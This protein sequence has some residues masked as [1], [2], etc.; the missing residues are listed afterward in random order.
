MVD[1]RTRRLLT[2]IRRYTR[3]AG[4]RSLEREISNARP[5]GGEGDPARRRRS[6]SIVD[7]RERWRTISACRSSATAR[8]RPRIRSAS[9][10]GLAWTEVGGELLT[11]EGV[12]MP[13]KGTM[14]VT[15][16]LR[17]V[18]KESI[19]AAT[20]YVALARRSSSAS[21]RRCSRR[22]DI[23]V[24]VPEGATPKDGPSAGVAMAT[25]IVSV[26]T[27]I[28]VRTDV[29]MT[30][31]ITL[32]GRVLPIGGLK[33]KLLA[34]L[35][36]GIK[37]VLIP[38]E[39]AKD[40]AELPRQREERAG[41][42]ARSRAW[43]RCWPSALTRKPEADRL[44]RG[45]ARQGK[46]PVLGEEEGPGMVAHRTRAAAGKTIRAARATRR[47]F[48][49]A[50]ADVGGCGLAIRAAAPYWK[51]PGRLAQ[52]VEHLVYTERVG[53]SSPSPPTIWFHTDVEEPAAVA[54]ARKDRRAEASALSSQAA[55]GCRRR[56]ARNL[57]HPGVAFARDGDASFGAVL[58]GRQR[59]LPP[60][61]F[62][63]RRGGRYARRDPRSEGGCAHLLAILACSSGRP[64]LPRSRGRLFEG[65]DRDPGSPTP[66]SCRRKLLVFR[67]PR[68]G[69]ASS[70]MIFRRTSWPVS[71]VRPWRA[72]SRRC[73]ELVRR[74]PR[75]LAALIRHLRD[76]RPTK[77]AVG[78]D[79]QGW[80]GCPTVGTRSSARSTIQEHQ[81]PV[82][83]PVTS[84]P[85]RKRAFRRVRCAGRR[86]RIRSDRA[87]REPGAHACS[88]SADGDT[89]RELAGRN[90][91]DRI[92]CPARLSGVDAD[93]LRV[94]LFADLRGEFEDRYSPALARLRLYYRDAYDAL[95]GLDLKKRLAFENEEQR[96]RQKAAEAAQHPAGPPIASS[97][98]DLSIALVGDANPWPRA[99]R[100][101][102]KASESGRDASALSLLSRDISKP[103]AKRPRRRFSNARPTP[104]S[105]GGGGGGGGGGGVGS[106]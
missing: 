85:A 15:G 100:L 101:W 19:S 72:P 45:A 32:R 31:E 90:A 104:M 39:N 17:D 2:L 51:A 3:E 5:Q 48:V 62:R 52:S 41:D 103:S 35:R 58:L 53:G 6:R 89:D 8:P 91:G 46:P 71:L 102:T 79:S 98:L 36:G 64:S 43:R 50:A 11:I 28:P 84:R 75:A 80:P 7:G 33:E 76:A 82:R 105:A 44:G 10:P 93:G 61:D 21:S 16:N 26:L 106:R 57:S 99:S 81:M 68:P 47:S 29:A 70:E 97:G 77:L 94:S 54:G 56:A 9:S 88:L 60:R 25:A 63:R 34:A 95:D 18:M 86:Y 1:R 14:T 49:R 66:R 23:H 20:S 65:S 37:T 40:L 38:E 87:D 13:G 74:G 42:R 4:V 92:A 73:A 27:G 55:A 12:L 78:I 22:R 96:A 24:H 59:E 67:A 69:A 83:H 30:G